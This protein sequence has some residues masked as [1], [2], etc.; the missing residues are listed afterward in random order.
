MIAVDCL[1]GRIILF[2]QYDVGNHNLSLNSQEIVP[3][4]V[5]LNEIFLINDMPIM[6]FRNVNIHGNYSI[7]QC[8][9]FI[10]YAAKILAQNL[11]IEEEEP[12]SSIEDIDQFKLTILALLLSKMIEHFAQ[13]PT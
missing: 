5:R 3:I 9:S 11:I 6:H 12:L 7:F 13:I 4:V 8:G 1:L 2:R 10:V